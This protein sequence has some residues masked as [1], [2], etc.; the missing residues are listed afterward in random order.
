LRN[1]ERFGYFSKIIFFLQRWRLLP[2]WLERLWIA[3]QGPFCPGLLASLQRGE[4]EPDVVVFFTYLYYP[5]VFGLPLVADRAVLVPTAHDEPAL[6]LSCIEPVFRL[7]RYLIFLTSEEQDLVQRHFSLDPDSQRVIGMGIE[8]REPDTRDEGYLLYVGRIEPGKNCEM[9]FDYC[10]ESGVQLKAIG[11]TLLPVP[12][13]IEYL[14]VVPEKEKNRLLAN[15]SGLVAPS[16]MESLSISV[17]EAW[18]HGKPAIVWDRS[19]VLKAQ[20]KRSGGGY[21]FTSLDD[22]QN[23][24]SSLD[25]H[26]G[27][28]GWKFVKEHYSWEKIL[29]QYESVFEEVRQARQ[30]APAGHKF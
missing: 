11:P 24:V 17:L 8:M 28:Q 29:K 14:G 2:L 4:D 25:P 19:P 1:W 10:R 13:H 12:D 16:A 27:I 30:G 15:C 23:I 20:V 7:P 5:T 9:M 22:F 6:R 3:S 26:R 18:A 21:S